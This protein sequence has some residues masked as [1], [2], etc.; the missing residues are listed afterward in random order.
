MAAPTHKTRHALYSN[1][2]VQHKLLKQGDEDGFWHCAFCDCLH[3]E[4]P[5]VVASAY[6]IVATVPQRCPDSFE[7]PCS[8]CGKVYQCKET[9]GMVEALVESMVAEG[10]TFDPDAEG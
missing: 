3:I 2:Y 9:C 10:F 4:M 6:H 8:E 7:K 1:Y 5:G